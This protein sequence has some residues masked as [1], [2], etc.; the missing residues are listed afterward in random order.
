MTIPP[1]SECY[2]T[3]T[4]PAKSWPALSGDI[5]V[6]VAIVG[7]GIVGV[8][9]ARLLQKLEPAGAKPLTERVRGAGYRMRDR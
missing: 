9:L 1:R 7:G 6:D 4:A 3:A 2:W 5:E 8:T